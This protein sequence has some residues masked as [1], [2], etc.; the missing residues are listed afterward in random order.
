M[1]TL[2]D[3][4]G[5]FANYPDWTL[6][7]ASNALRLLQACDKLEAL[8]I[9]DGIEFKTNPKTHTQVSGEKYGGF[10]PRDCPFGALH[11]SH[12]EGCA[13]DRYDPQ[14]AIDNWLLLNEPVLVDCG[15]YIE[16][17]IATEGWS[18]WSI[19]PPA[20]GHHIFMP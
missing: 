1:I 19:K 17:P 5:K 6:S 15:I 20:S 8:M 11:S 13:V 4:V 7:R 16:H 14:N 12:K 2:A 3:Y 18:H 9:A 10:R